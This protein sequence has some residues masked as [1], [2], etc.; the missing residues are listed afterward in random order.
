M[1]E[2]GYPAITVVIAVLNKEALLSRCLK[3]IMCQSFSHYEFIVIDGGSSDGTVEIIQN[4]R[5][6]I[7]YWESRPDRGV[8]HAWNKALEHA[9]GEWICFLGADDYFW[10]KNVLAKFLPHLEEA[11]SEGK[12]IVY[13]KICK[14]DHNEKILSCL[15]K[16]WPRIGWLLRHGMILPHPGLMHH[17][18]LFEVHGEF[19]ESFRIA[20]DYDLL[21]RELRTN[22]AVFVDDLVTVGSQVGGI[23]DSNNLLAHREV[24]RARR[25]NG[26]GFSPIWHLINLRNLCRA[27]WRRKV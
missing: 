16:P 27:Y 3:S 22:T 13:G 17:K 25:K 15:G 12:R 7:S 5:E 4:N 24:A 2:K 18:S 19:D 9:K 6:N 10:D 23:S 26:L 8:Y 20:G 11:A 14:V 21:L 1:K